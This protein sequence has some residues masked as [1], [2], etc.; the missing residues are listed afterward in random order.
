[1]F[2]YLLVTQFLNFKNS[3][4]VFCL[5][6]RNGSPFLESQWFHFQSLVPLM[7]SSSYILS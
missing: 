2:L 1:M 3:V 4:L 5:L 7:D 6:R